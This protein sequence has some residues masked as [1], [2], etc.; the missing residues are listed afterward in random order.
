MNSIDDE[1][2]AA[3]V[4]ADLYYLVAGSRINRRYVAPGAEINTGHYAPQRVKIRNARPFQTRLGFDSHGFVLAQHMSRVADFTDPAQIDAGYVGEVIDVVRRVTGATRVLPMGWMMR[5]SGDLPAPAKQTVGYTHQGG[6]Q[7]PASDV[8]VDMAPDRAHRFAKTLYEKHVPGGLDYRRFIATSCWRAFSD[9]PQDWPLA[10][11]D[12]NSVDPTEGVKNTMVIVDALPEPDAALREL[13]G[14]DNLPAASVFH[15]NPKHRW[16]YFPNMTRDE[17]LLVKFHDSD[18]S[19]A[20]RAPHTSFRDPTY[21]GARVRRSIEF[22]T[23]AYF[24]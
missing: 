12:G 20:W 13:P 9:P 4:E 6:I 2:D 15:F 21:P 16:W 10:V 11:C 3:G 14:E 1:T 8:H 19:T 7:P 17:V 5:S 23:V 18:H 24:D 22:R